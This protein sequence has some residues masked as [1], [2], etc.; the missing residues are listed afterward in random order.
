M[1]CTPGESRP[2]GDG[3]NSC[4]CGEDGIESC[5]AAG[6]IRGASSVGIHYP[7]QSLSA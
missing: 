6:C 7:L 3:C 1:G 5:T 2:A 4:T